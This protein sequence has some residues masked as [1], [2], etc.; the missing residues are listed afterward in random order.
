MPRF[1]LRFET[2]ADVDL[3][4]ITRDVAS[5]VQQAGV[6]EGVAACFTPGST[7]AL[8]T[9]EYESGCL[10]DLA[11]A[12]DQIAPRRGDYH[13][14]ARWGDGNGYSH[15]RA[16]LLGPALTVP[17]SGGELELG[18]WQQLMLCDFDNKPRQRRVVVRVLADA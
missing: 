1:E 3:I 18:T 15:L 14:N 13:H 8:T 2:S 9:I 17:V 10:R 6:A 4:D 11:E 16:A 12:L 5:C 7:A